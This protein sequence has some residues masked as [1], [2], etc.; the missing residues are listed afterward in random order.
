MEVKVVE[1]IPL[2]RNTMQ[3]FVTVEIAELGLEIPGFGIHQR[4][5]PRW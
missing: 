5:G 1:F 4:G 2:E 3:G